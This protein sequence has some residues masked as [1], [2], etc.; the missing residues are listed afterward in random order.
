[1]V[2]TGEASRLTD[3]FRLTGTVFEGRFKIEREIAEG[4]F[5]VVYRARHLALDRPVALKVL[6]TPRDHGETSRAEFQARFAAEAKTIA[7]LK[8]PNIVD[9][10]DFAIGGMPN[11][12]SAPWMALE[13]LDGETLATRLL[14]RRRLG[15]LPARDALN[16]F[17]PV[18]QALAFAHQQGI[19]HRD[20]KP[21]NI[22]VVGGDPRP[23]LQVLDF[24]IAKMVD[25]ERPAGSGDTRTDSLPAFT[26][27]YA[28]PEQVAY[29]RTG[30]WTDVHALGLILTELMTDAPPY[31]DADAH[32]FEQ[33]MSAD[34]PTPKSKGVDAGAFEA[35]IAKALALSPRER[36]ADAGELLAALDAAAGLADATVPMAPAPAPFPRGE[37]TRA[38]P[39]RRAPLL[40]VLAAGVAAVVTLRAATRSR[41]APAAMPPIVAPAEPP[42]APPHPPAAPEA[43]S[44]RE[45]PFVPMPPAGH[46]APAEQTTRR[47]ARAKRPAPKVAGGDHGGSHTNEVR[48]KDLFDDTK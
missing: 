27:S 23:S 42:P 16:L 20:I 35:I 48:V 13:W 19:V 5:A 14:R 34:R 40:V 22:M 12:E 30:S 8:H 7:R 31:A 17:R 32:L 11:G 9:V 43:S 6:K 24:G 47:A 46:Q 2:V 28:A 25:A 36:W 1:M 45:R 18:I 4:G 21:A 10:Y 37:P 29:S 39:A 3:A 38:K 41:Q 44:V 15:G 26:P 33:V